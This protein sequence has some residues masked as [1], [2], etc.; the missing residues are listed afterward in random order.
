V[1]RTVLI[2]DDSPA[3]RE[4]ATALLTE[5]G[6]DV[7]ST[8]ANEEE[9]LEAAAGGCPDG[10]LLDINLPGRDG[11]AVA[12]LL[13]VAC[14]AA[15]IVLTSANFADVPPEALRECAAVA[16]VPKEELA[17]ADLAAL[18]MPEGT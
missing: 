13:A 12:T 8:A 14:P 7:L 5:R 1:V 3:F 18:F 16:F 2:V 17:K 4:A 11:F 9:A 10:V 6:F 15:R